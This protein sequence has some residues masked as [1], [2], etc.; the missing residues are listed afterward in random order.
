MRS[1]LC[2]CTTEKI[3]SCSASAMAE[4]P[5]FL[6][7]KEWEAVDRTERTEAVDVR[8]VREEVG[9]DLGLARRRRVMRW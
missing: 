6:I 3:T 5:A 9:M 8:R 7:S 2:S 1:G 4:G